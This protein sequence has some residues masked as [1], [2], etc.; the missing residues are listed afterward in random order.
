M[1]T[2]T[3]GKPPLSRAF[4]GYC[5]GFRAAMLGGFL[6][7]LVGC[8]EPSEREYKNRRELEALLTAITL[9]NAKELEKD[10]RRIE[11]RHGLWELSDPNYKELKEIIEKARAGDW[12]KA[13][14]RAYE[15]REQHPFFD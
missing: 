6:L 8:G 14:K 3:E 2:L 5:P 10:A 4:L 12:A 15:F 7:A 13:E 1:L 9:K 11:Q